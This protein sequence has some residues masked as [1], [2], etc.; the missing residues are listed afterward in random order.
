MRLALILALIGMPALADAQMTTQTC[1]KGWQTLI[2]TLGS[3]NSNSGNERTRRQAVARA[4]PNTATPDGWCRMLGADLGIGG[5]HFTSLDWQADDLDL[6]LDGDGLPTG[7]RLRMAGLFFDEG[8]RAR[9]DA[10]VALRRIPGQPGVIIDTLDLRDA[11]GAGFSGSGQVDGG[12]VDTLSMAMMS[13][14]EM[15]LTDLSLIA[16]VTP[17]LMSDLAAGWTAT[18]LDGA[19]ADLTPD[20]IDDASRSAATAFFAALPNATGQLTAGLHSDA[21]VGTLD[22]IVAFSHAKSAPLSQALAIYLDGVT[23][24]LTWLPR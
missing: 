9:Y 7:L 13:A 19:L 5:K 12:M 24:T 15:R 11:A 22:A 18:A 2:D 20:Q 10:A 6:F 14:A 21:G 8:S 16:D 3:F 17:G 1:T 4:I 23:S